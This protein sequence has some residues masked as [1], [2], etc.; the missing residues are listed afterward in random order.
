MSRARSVN[1]S[2]SARQRSA[3]RMKVAL[4]FCLV[5]FLMSASTYS[6]AQ[7]KPALFCNG[8][9]IAISMLPE[10]RMTYA[11]LPLRSGGSREFPKIHFNSDEPLQFVIRDRSHFGDFWK[12]A[13]I[14]AIPGVGVPPMP[15]IDFSKEMLVAV[16]MGNRPTPGYWI[17][18]DGACVR[19]DSLE[20]FVTSIDPARCPSSFEG[21]SAAADIVVLPRTDLP[22]VFHEN[23]VD[24]QQWMEQIIR[25]N[26]SER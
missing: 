4:G 25:S 13:V 16:V 24:C 6:G 11:P 12:R 21:G 2:P 19:Q 9:P 1:Q 8:R 17:Y 7:E 18:I 15:E 5:M 26:K 22:V 23:R 10:P 20:V 14:F 3:D